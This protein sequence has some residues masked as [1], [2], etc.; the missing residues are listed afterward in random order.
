MNARKLISAVSLLS[1]LSSQYQKVKEKEREAESEKF[2]F[3]KRKQQT[4]PRY[5]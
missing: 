3:A 4:V 5:I 1:I 2:L